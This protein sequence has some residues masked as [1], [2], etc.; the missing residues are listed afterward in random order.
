MAKARPGALN[1]ASAQRG[2]ANHLAAELF[3]SMAGV[4]I[5]NISFSSTGLALTSLIG[6]EVQLSFPTA[7]A[8]VPHIK[9]GRLRGLALTSAEPSALFPGMPTVAAS[10]PGYEAVS[11]TAIFAPAKTPATIISRLHQEIVRVLNQ[12]D[13][14]EKF[15][16]PES[17]S[18]AAS[19]SNWLRR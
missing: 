14:R 3:K 5:V 12:A 17:R 9:S 18:S 11:I 16:M 13:V 10:L 2:A 6:G 19:R 4:N 7:G 8:A 15:P 1:S